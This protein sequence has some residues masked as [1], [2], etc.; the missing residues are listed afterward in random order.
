M[1]EYHRMAVLAHK[2]GAER[3]IENYFSLTGVRLKWTFPGDDSSGTKDGSI[4]ANP[5]R[6]VGPMIY[7]GMD[8]ELT[9][10]SSTHASRFGLTMGMPIPYRW[11]FYSVGHTTKRMLAAGDVLTGYM[12][13]CLITLW[14]DEVRYVGHVGTADYSA[15]I[16]KKVKG[17][18]AAAMPANTTGFDPAG[19]WGPAE[20]R[21]KQQKFKLFAEPKILALVTTSQRFYSV[22][23]FK[24]S[25]APNT[26]C[27]GGI[28]EV[29]PMNRDALYLR[30]KKLG[31]K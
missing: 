17:R 1:G 16:S 7:D 9:S 23:L 2:R 20:I 3:M 12:S 25:G 14:T 13:G 24:L 19:A 28:R 21:P 30:M 27:V 26:W 10:P 29:P 11:L 22:L 8:G 5:D 15:E 31:D 4:I 6:G 18:F